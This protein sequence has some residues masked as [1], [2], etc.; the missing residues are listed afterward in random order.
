[1]YGTYP[2]PEQ[3]CTQVALVQRNFSLTLYI[4]GAYIYHHSEVSEFSVLWDLTPSSPVDIYQHAGGTWTSCLHLHKGISFAWH[5]FFALR[6]VHYLMLLYQLQ[7]VFVIE[8]VD[9]V[10]VVARKKTW[11]KRHVADWWLCPC[12]GT[13]RSLAE[14]KTGLLMNSQTCLFWYV[15][16]CCV[17]LIWSQ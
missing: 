11:R 3:C 9:V 5:K 7:R 6:F 16:S 4:K 10:T 12:R 1:M 14:Y 15:V 17:F 2:L 8:C 13:N